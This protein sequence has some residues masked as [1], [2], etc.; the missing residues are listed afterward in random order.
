MT[1]T[2]M[3]PAHLTLDINVRKDADLN[4][5]FL[6]SISQHGVIQPV[7]AHQTSDGSAHVIMGQRRTLA[8]VEVGLESIPVHLVAS[9]EEADR[10]AQQVVENDMRTKLTDADRADAFHQMSLIGV[11]ASKIAKKTGSTKETVA[12]ALK[13]KA[14]ATAAEALDYGMTIEQ[15]SIVEEFSTDE[16]AVAKLQQCATNNPQN[17]GHIAQQLR[18]ERARAEEV[19]ALEA[20]A[21]SK[22]LAISEE[23]VNY[24]DYKGPS[25]KISDLTH[26]DG[27]PLTEADADAVCIV[28]AYKVYAT[29][30]VMDW[31]ARGFLKGG[32]SGSGMTDEQRAERQELIANNKA[33]DAAI[34]VRQDFLKT[35][36][37]KKSLPKDAPS[38]IAW[39]VAF[40]ANR[41]NHALGNSSFAAG[42]LGREKHHEE[43]RKYVSQANSSPEKA[44]LATMLAAFELTC[45]RQ[46]WRRPS[47][48][49]AT[50]LVTLENWGYTPSEVERIII[51]KT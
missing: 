16:N 32:K 23:N 4:A 30:V 45:D 19:K 41:L 39:T 27:S 18:D 24:Y 35:L 37:T 49:M 25:A 11:S 26:P 20:E 34:T 1:T 22:G 43:M 51:N 29:P 48:T 15:A 5:T 47:K 50:Y 46:D 31:K 7:I 42:L 3:N 6:E 10:L 33:M 36:L 44:T 21:I 28:Q 40:N 9:L 12:Q 14:N 8:A 13:V 2:L 17:F 38:F